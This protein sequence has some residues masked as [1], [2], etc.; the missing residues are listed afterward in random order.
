MRKM[1]STTKDS[2]TVLIFLLCTML[3]CTELTISMP[4]YP[5]PSRTPV[6]SGGNSTESERGSSRDQVRIETIKK[7]ILAS[8]NMTEPPS[9][10]VVARARAKITPE[11]MEEARSLYEETVRIYQGAKSVF[12]KRQERHPTDKQR[13]VHQFHAVGR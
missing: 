12:P 3:L 7:S 1:E 5:S 2:H 11:W 4:S 6:H 8:L 9:P 10:E 13:R